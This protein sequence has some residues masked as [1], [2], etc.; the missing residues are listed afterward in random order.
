MDDQQARFGEC[1]MFR[2]NRRQIGEAKNVAEKNA[3]LL[4]LTIGTQAIE[5]FGT[6][7]ER[8]KLLQVL[9]KI[10]LAIEHAWSRH[11]FEQLRPANEQIARVP[12][13]VECFHEQLEQLRVHDEQLEE[14][15]AE[16]VR[17]DET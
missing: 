5:R 9:G 15:A 8:F 6:D 12:A 1:G 4:A 10:A 11:F 14:H 17:F 13:G 3:E 7:V 16:S 2:E